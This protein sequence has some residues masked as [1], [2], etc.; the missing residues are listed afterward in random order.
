M[1]RRWRIGAS[2]ASKDPAASPLVT[3]AEYDPA[4]PA[5]E[6][7]R[8]KSDRLVGSLLRE[9]AERAVAAV[10]DNRLEAVRDMLGSLW[11]YVDWRYCTKQLTT[12]QKELWA[13]AV[14]AWSADLNEGSI[15]APLVADRW[16]L[17]PTC[18][19]RNRDVDPDAPHEHC[20]YAEREAS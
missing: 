10:N 2:W 17:C 3:I 1:T 18:G 11:L 5:D 16:W 9:D 12:V 8:R 13:A 19:I 6:Q 4:E 14:E 15:E 7:G 20:A